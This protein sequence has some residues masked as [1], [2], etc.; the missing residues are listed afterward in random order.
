MERMTLKQG[1]CR[2]AS[3]E[4]CSK[5]KDCYS[6][7]YG[8]KCFRLLAAY[9]DTGLEPEEIMGLCSMHE[10]AKMAE[11]LRA[12]DSRPLTLDELREMDGEPVWVELVNG[13]HGCWLIVD[14]ELIERNVGL[15]SYQNYGVWGLAYR[16]KPDEGTRNG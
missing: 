8:R 13:T 15:L 12:E 6:C 4:F 11:L 10:R 5:H 2:M 16:R 14:T 3:T 9:E 7:E 1:V